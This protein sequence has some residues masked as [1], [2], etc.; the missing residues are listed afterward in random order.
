MCGLPKR[1]LVEIV[2]KSLLVKMEERKKSGEKRLKGAKLK[3]IIDSHVQL[4]LRELEEAQGRCQAFNADDPLFSPEA[5]REDISAGLALKELTLMPLQEAV[6]AGEQYFSAEHRRPAEW[7]VAAASLKTAKA[8]LTQWRLTQPKREQGDKK[9]R[10]LV[11]AQLEKTLKGG[12]SE[13][14]KSVAAMYLKVDLREMRM[15]V[16]LS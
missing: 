10:A 7:A 12:D 5:L 2:S 16:F 1:R 6:E 4:S 8:S 9:I 13:D 15:K 11:A 3:E 14:R